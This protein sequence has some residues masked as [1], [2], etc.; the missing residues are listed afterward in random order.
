M[1]SIFAILLGYVESPSSVKMGFQQNCSGR[2]FT[3]VTIP[4][5]SQDFF[6]NFACCGKEQSFCTADREKRRNSETPKNHGLP[7]SGLYLYMYVLYIYMYVFNL[8]LYIYVCV[9]AP[10]TIVAV[11]HG[12][13][14]PSYHFKGGLTRSRDH[15][16]AGFGGWLMALCVLHYWDYHIFRY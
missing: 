12:T 10:Q 13:S 7:S 6:N 5:S 4:W 8:F 3:I 11:N 9:Y 1:S 2:L 16:L 15:R 14:Q